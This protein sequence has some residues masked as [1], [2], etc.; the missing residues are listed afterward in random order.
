MGS[1]EYRAGGERPQ[2]VAHDM[3]SALG[4]RLKLLT[5][6]PRDLPAR[7]RTLESAIEWSYDLLDE[8]E[9]KV[10]CGLSVFVGSYTLE[11]IDAVY[12]GGD[13]TKSGTQDH[14][15]SLVNKSL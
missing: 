8:A 13:E 9:R 4:S 2:T 5:G 15:A 1:N 11:A 7:Q 3:H 14:V 12:T 10:F 6:G